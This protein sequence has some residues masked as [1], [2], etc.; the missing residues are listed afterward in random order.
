M[1]R[2]H[3]WCRTVS[4]SG[5]E[6][7]ER[8]TTGIQRVRSLPHGE[9]NW[10]CRGRELRRLQPDGRNTG[11]HLHEGRGLPGTCVA[12]RARTTRSEARLLQQRQGPVPTQTGER[13]RP[14]ASLKHGPNTGNGSE[15]CSRA[16]GRSNRSAGPLSIRISRRVRREAGHRHMLV[17]ARRGVVS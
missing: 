15:T 2:R 17:S 1:T 16:K 10:P 12:S 13:D 4:V 6:G 14:K 9:P 3:L 8:H 5:T 7:Y 11:L